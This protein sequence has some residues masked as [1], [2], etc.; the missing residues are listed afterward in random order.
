MFCETNPDCEVFTYY[1]ETKASSCTFRRVIQT[2]QVNA[3]S[4]DRKTLALFMASD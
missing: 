2:A 1:T 4:V 3:V